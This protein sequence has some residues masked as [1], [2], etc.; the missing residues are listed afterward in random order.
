MTEKTRTLVFTATYNECDSIGLFLQGVRSELP[1][2]DVLICDDRSPDGTADEVRR[3][4][5]ADPKISLVERPRKLGVGTAHKLAMLYALKHGY[6]QLITMD[7]D[8]SHSPQDLPKMVWALKEAPMV[9]GS[10]YMEGGQ[11][12]Y[13]G[14][15]DRLSRYANQVARLLLGIKIHETTTSFRGFQRHVLET[16][17]LHGI[18]NNGYGFF[19]ACIYLTH[20]LGFKIKEFPIHFVDRRFG[21]SKISSKEIFA[22]MLLLLRLTLER[23]R[24]WPLPEKANPLIEATCPLCNKDIQI[25]FIPEKKARKGSEAYRCTSESHSCHGRIVQCLSCGLVYMNP[26][27]DSDEILA[28]YQDVQDDQYL[29]NIP[30]RMDT[31]RYNLTAIRRFLPKTGSLLDMGSYCGVFLKVAKNQGY[32]VKGVEPSRWAA[33]YANEQM[34]V[35]TVRGTL[36]DV[37]SPANG[38]DVITSWD[39]L[40]HLSHPLDEM[41]KVHQ[42]LKAGG[43][44]VFST[45]NIDS[46]PTRLLGER[47][48]WWMDMH[49]YYY[50]KA[51]TQQMVE[52]AGFKLVNAR[53]YCHIITLEYFLMKLGALGVPG[54]R[55]L[56]SLLPRS[57]QKKIRIP[58]RFG[59]IQLY[60]CQKA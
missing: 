43:L 38:F 9:I 59:D 49:L 56:M 35:P 36:A 5:K 51:I 2:A 39:V 10:R 50:D 17:P 8:L 16:L 37:E 46:W 19:F 57:L 14:F 13:S 60:V 3:L 1:E 44:F 18:R 45:L 30:S 34:G 15:R 6:D 42:K 27:P 33:H 52:M 20:K 41:K 29:A 53:S 40:E 48:P 7:A 55:V 32:D 12:G 22:A 24:L 23:L 58:F 21:Q 4:K 25:E 26:K 28:M 31:F 47:W 54:M 11:S